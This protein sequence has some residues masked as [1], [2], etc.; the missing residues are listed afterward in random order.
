MKRL[1]L[2]LSLAVLVVEGTCGSL[3]PVRSAVAA[4]GPCV[5]IAD[6]ILES[7]QAD[8]TDELWLAKARCENLP[9]KD[10]VR[11]CRQEAKNEKADAKGACVDQHAARLQVCADV[12]TGVYRP[13][14]DPARFVSR[15]D[16]RY[17]PLP[18]G[19]TFV[20]ES[21]TEHDEVSV[22]HATKTILGVSCTVVRDVVTLKPG[23]EVV[24]DTLDYFAQD[25]AGNVWYFGEE[26]KQFESGE[27]IG[28]DG[29]WKAGRDDA[30]PGIVMEAQPAVGDVYRQ[31][32]A[33]AEAEDLARVVS[34]NESAS[35]PYG[36]FTGVLKTED[37]SP[38]DEAPEQKFYAAG[39]GNVLETTVD[40]E[41]LELVNVTTE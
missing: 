28:I 35:V 5:R 8:T 20:F 39:V 24:E 6:A 14:I 22:T 1:P 16:N 32:F 38:L 27:L 40:G 9:T 21:A 29:S 13:A 15:V 19:T 10:A 3:L 11:T 23:G 37:F 30:Q 2:R 26:A 18:P 7:C 4:G 12:G 34:L 33:A 25:V 36:S 17:F 31:E 41:R